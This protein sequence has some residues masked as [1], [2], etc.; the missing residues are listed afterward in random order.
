MD[1]V[2]R[3]RTLRDHIRCAIVELWSDIGMQTDSHIFHLVKETVP[4]L[5]YAEFRTVFDDLCATVEKGSMNS[6]KL[7]SGTPCAPKRQRDPSGE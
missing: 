3:A 1:G 2:D 7:E 4:T 6:S 5:T